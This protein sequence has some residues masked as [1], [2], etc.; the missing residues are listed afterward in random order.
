MRM[1]EFEVQFC[2]AM[3]SEKS[4]T[5]KLKFVL[6]MLVEGVLFGKEPKNYIHG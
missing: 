2:V 1:S 6:L 5:R 3:A 4:S